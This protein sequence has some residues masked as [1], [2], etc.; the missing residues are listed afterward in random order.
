LNII[1]DAYDFFKGLACHPR[2]K[3]CYVEY[4]C[5]K[6]YNLANSKHSSLLCKQYN[7]ATCDNSHYYCT[8]G[9]V[10]LVHGD[11]KKRCRCAKG[12]FGSECHSDNGA[13]FAQQLVYIGN[14]SK[15]PSQLTYFQEKLHYVLLPVERLM[16]L[17]YQERCNPE[18]DAAAMDLVQI[19][20][21]IFKLPF[22]N[23]DELLKLSQYLVGENKQL[24]DYRSF[25]RCSELG[26]CEPISKSRMKSYKVIPVPDYDREWQP[27][28]VVV[29]Q[30]NEIC[31][32][33]HPGE[34]ELTPKIFWN[35]VKWFCP[36]NTNCVKTAKLEGRCLCHGKLIG[37]D[38]ISRREYEKSLPP[39]S[40]YEF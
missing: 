4:G 3:T 8:P 7:F 39:N 1:A 32:E 35:M 25:L 11:G 34:F 38:C 23:F 24:C 30:P 6:D 22:E 29:F 17:G 18:V 15:N 12:T 10:C 13:F 26:K 33:T 5:P 37:D 40:T 19:I 9:A 31:G 36:A 28:I 2:K 20:G 27:T 14:Y 21:N 16:T